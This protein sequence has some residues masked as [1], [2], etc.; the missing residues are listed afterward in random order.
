MPIYKIRNWNG[1]YENHETRK[2]KTLTW[3]S[4]RNKMDGAGYTELVDH[5]C[6]PAH[7]AAWIAILEIAS[8]C[9][10]R[11]TLVREKPITPREMARVSR[12]PEQLFVDV[13]PRLV[14]IGWLD[15]EAI[16]GETHTSAFACNAS[17][18]SGRLPG[19]FREMPGESGKSTVRVPSH[20][21]LSV[22]RARVSKDIANDYTMYFDEWIKP[23]ARVPNLQNAAQA[24]IST[25][26]SNEDVGAAF[27]VRDRYLESDEVSRGVWMSP[28]KFLFEQYKNGWTGR[29]PKPKPVQSEKKPGIVERAIARHREEGRNGTR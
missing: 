18:E 5:P 6:G 24:W 16:E 17:G 12:F 27:A 10:T 4:V 15:S 3:V 2:L 8:R 14:E 1:L 9:P 22:P 20:S 26:D 21:F 11:G 29:W 13:L 7:F 19:D 25:V 28:E 23:W